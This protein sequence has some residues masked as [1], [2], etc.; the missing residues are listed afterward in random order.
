M[1]RPITIMNR[2]LNRMPTPSQHAKITNEN[3][4][5]QFTAKMHE[6]TL[7]AREREVEELAQRLG[8]GSVNLKGFV[9]SPETLLSIPREQAEEL[10]VICF[11]H[12]GSEIRVGAIDPEA[13]AVRELVFQLG[14]RHSA[15]A[16]RYA[17]SEE[18]FAHAMKLYDAVPTIHPVEKQVTISADDFTRV[19]EQLKDLTA[20]E[21]LFERVDTS[22][23]VTLVLVGAIRVRSSDIHIEAEE[24]G[25]ALRYRIDGVLKNVAIIPKQRWSQLISR[26]KLLA[27]LKMNVDR[28]P[29]DGRI[30]IA[31]AE[32]SIDVRVSTLPTSWGE[33]V[34]MRLL[35]S[36]KTGLEFADL[37]IRGR[38]FE[39]LTRE[40]GRPNGMI[41]T[42]GPTGSGKTT[43][44]YSV[45]LKLNTE[46]TKIITLEDPIEYKLKGINQSQIDPSREYTFAKGLRA[47]LRQDPDI[48]MVGEIRDLET[49][50]VAIQAALTGH[51]MLSTIHTNSAAG[52][53]PRFL[54]MGVKPFLLAPAL[55]AI[56]GQRLVRKVCEACREP[57]PLTDEERTRVQEIIAQIPEAERAEAET[58][59]L[60]FFR[61]KGCDECTQTGY[62]GRVGIYEIL[63]MSK[64]IEDVVLSGKVS[65]YQMAE[66]AQKAGMV[67]MVQDGILKALD[68][69]TSIEEVFRVS[70]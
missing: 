52:A 39:Q 59:E 17:I 11:L 60:S 43:T 69:V 29:Q 9:I 62:K 36:S 67:T 27:G 25:V 24:E 64:E 55:N 46:K 49:S 3:I 57:A 65:E 44:L 37:G 18:S 45:L 15:N 13:E 8:V 1:A 34:V 66:L 53:I 68:G 61:G 58:K 10:R 48:V 7:S 70:E 30:T 23:L 54:S 14:E 35:M 51:L 19:T 31:L 5:E 6:L 2:G 38:A 26:L 47:I 40:V 33:S 20:L 42:T 21:Q 41:V 28:V 63:I 4:A 32:D 50:E 22:D 12:S 16:Q 56:I